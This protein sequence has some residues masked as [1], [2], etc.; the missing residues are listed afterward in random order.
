AVDR[1][2]FNGDDTKQTMLFRA[3]INNR[4][5]YATDIPAD[6]GNKHLNTVRPRIGF[7]DRLIQPQKRGFIIMSPHNDNF[8]D[9]PAFLTRPPAPDTHFVTVK[10]GV[11]TGSKIG[12]ALRHPG[13]EVLNTFGHHLSIR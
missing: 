13:T 3:V 11:N 4:W 2:A 6:A 8:V 9:K 1:C 5:V 10:L 12:H 7:V